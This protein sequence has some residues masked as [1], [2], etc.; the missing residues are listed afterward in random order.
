MDDILVDFENKQWESPGNGVR[1]KSFLKGNQRLRLVEFSEGF[2]EKDWCTRGHAGYVLEGSCTIDFK[3]RLKSFG[4]GDV[5]FIPEGQEYG[6]K[7]L[8]NKGEK[9]LFLLFEIV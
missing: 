6:H 1:F 7:V 3:G 8:I 9:V 5:L 2:E 4:T